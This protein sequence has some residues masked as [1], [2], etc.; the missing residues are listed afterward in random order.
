MKEL[1]VSRILGA[2][3]HTCIFDEF[4]K[5]DKTEEEIDKELEGGIRRSAQFYFD[6]GM[7]ELEVPEAPNDNK[8]N[9]FYKNAKYRHKTKKR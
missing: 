6:D 8:A 1:E 2:S 7:K 4:A 3:V 5:I 9:P